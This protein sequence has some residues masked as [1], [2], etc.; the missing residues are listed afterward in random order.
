MANCAFAIFS[1]WKDKQT[2]GSRS[3]S[4]IFKFIHQNKRDRCSFKRSL[5]DKLSPLVPFALKKKC[6]PR[7]YLQIRVNAWKNVLLLKTSD[8]LTRITTKIAALQYALDLSIVIWNDIVC[9][10][11]CI[12][13][14]VCICFGVFLFFPQELVARHCSRETICVTSWM[15]CVDNAHR[16]HVVFRFERN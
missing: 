4:R 7:F 5:C 9:E 6:L 11:Y 13:A 12:Q 10:R 15:A 14:A 16:V 2:D 8:K 1:I 3:K